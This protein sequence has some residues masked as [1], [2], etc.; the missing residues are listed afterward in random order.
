MKQPTSPRAF[1]TDKPILPGFFYLIQSGTIKKVGS[2]GSFERTK[3][4]GS[5]EVV[6]T[7]EKTDK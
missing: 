1:S 7:F 2:I 3:L 5:W 6:K 4:E